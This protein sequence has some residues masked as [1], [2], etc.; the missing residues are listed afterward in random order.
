MMQ[1]LI[2][3]F[4]NK[5]IPLQGTQDDWSEFESHF[6]TLY[7]VTTV[8]TLGVPQSVWETSNGM[9]HFAHAALYWRVG[10]D[11]FKNDGGKIFTGE[12][13]DLQYSTPVLPDDRVIWK[14]KFAEFTYEEKD[15]D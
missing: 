2:D 14:P 13:S 10:M 8:D 15:N 1:M 11:K 5:K 9:D 4:A 3:D 12:V 6:A 7:K